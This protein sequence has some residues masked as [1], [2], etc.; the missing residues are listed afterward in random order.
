MVSPGA[1]PDKKQKKNKLTT[2]LGFL[3]RRYTTIRWGT[4]LVFLLWCIISVVSQPKAHDAT[5]WLVRIGVLLLLLFLSVVALNPKEKPPPDIDFLERR[6]MTICSGIVILLMIWFI[7]SFV[8][9]QTAS[10]STTNWLWGICGF[11]ALLLAAAYALYS[12]QW[13]MG[14]RKVP[15]PLIW[16]GKL[17]P[18]LAGLVIGTVGAMIWISGGAINSSFSHFLGVICSLAIVLANEN[19]PRWIIGGVSVMVYLLTSLPLLTSLTSHT[20]L[21]GLRSWLPLPDPFILP[22]LSLTLFHGSCFI[23]SIVLALIAAPPGKTEAAKEPLR[24]SIAEPLISPTSTDGEDVP[25][26]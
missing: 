22:G 25:I 1:K 9:K 6:Y 13:G 20:L 7:F 10:Q 12:G 15:I 14:A 4:F 16:R 17:L 2:T 18:W 8:A 19:K 3:K 5:K 21:T 24:D 11:L 26:T 23:I